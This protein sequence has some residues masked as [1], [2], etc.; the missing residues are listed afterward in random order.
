M[1]EPSDRLAVLFANEAFYAAFAGR[2]LAALDALWARRA[3]V[4][5]IHPGWGPLF[6]REAVMESWQGIV[7]GRHP[8]RISC[9]DA[10]ATLLGDV[11]A[12]VCL[13]RVGATTLAATNLFVREDGAW[14]L[15]HHQAGPCPPLATSP[16]PTPPERLQ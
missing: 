13:E 7:G 15:V 12:V 5:C 9:H 10:R 3:M 1:A 16:P 8:P 14:K 11:A 4:S 6:G 2:D